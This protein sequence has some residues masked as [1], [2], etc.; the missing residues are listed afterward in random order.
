MKKKIFALAT[1]ALSACLILSGCGIDADKV[2]P[3]ASQYEYNISSL[4][5]V[6]SALDGATFAGSISDLGNVIVTKTIDS[7]PYYGV[8]NVQKGTIVEDYLL[9]DEMSLI[10]TT[11]SKNDYLQIKITNNEGQTTYSVKIVG[12]NY[13]YQG[14]SE[15]AE[16]T[17]YKFGNKYH[18]IWTLSDGSGTW[19]EQFTVSS[20]GKRTLVFSSKLEKGNTYGMG[21][22]AILALF[23]SSSALGKSISYKL[24]EKLINYS[25]TID[26][27]NHIKLYRIK[28]GKQVA[29]YTISEL[30]TASGTCLVDTT[31]IVQTK[32]EISANY[33]NYTYS[34]S[35][36]CYLVKTYAYNLLTGKKTELKTNFVLSNSGLMFASHDDQALVTGNEIKDHILGGYTLAYVNEDFKYEPTSLA[37]CFSIKIN[38]NRYFSLDISLELSGGGSFT[39]EYSYSIS[40]KNG[41]LIVKIDTASLSYF[42]L[43]SKSFMIGDSELERFALVDLNGKLLT[44]YDYNNVEAYANGYYVASKNVEDANANTT[45]TEYY[46]VNEK[47][48]AE[49]LIGKS[50]KNNLTSETTLYYG[51]VICSSINFICKVDSLS[52]QEVPKL[53]CVETLNGEKY[54]Y[55]IY[56]IEGK[57]LAKITN[58]DKLSNTSF[59]VKEFGLWGQHFVLCVGNNA[60]VFEN[61]SKNT[62]K[63]SATQI[64]L[65]FG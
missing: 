3:V 6:T 32:E 57:E 11:D 63:K 52:G 18:E 26:S 16:L 54:D 31:L 15:S 53:I 36:G 39:P 28:D 34:D 38:S 13:I 37:H 12:G 44:N 51:D 46:R 19:N 62:I 1:V 59:S 64:A 25:A 49:T 55:T 9:V 48:G 2:N 23:N 24:A 5:D 8:F 47:T 7:E 17:D 50:V 65:M 27:S 41:K 43:G 61:K 22:C 35:T 58:V 40:D 14:L 4:K 29:D 20:K 21:D 60:Y 33:E 30:N 56:N 45:T 10:E 42:V